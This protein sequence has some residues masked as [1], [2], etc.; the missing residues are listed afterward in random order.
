LF[1]LELE[2]VGYK[3][4]VFPDKNDES[5][6]QVGYLPGRL[7]DEDRCEANLRE[8]GMEVVNKKMDDSTFVDR[9]LISGASQKA[10]QTFSERC[11]AVLLSLPDKPVELE[12]GCFKK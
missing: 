9:E 4:C 7:K 11:V 3:L 12:A 8:L 6:P 2:L 10:A 5:S 1:T